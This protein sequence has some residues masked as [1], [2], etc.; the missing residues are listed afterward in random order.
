M[1]T[2]IQPVRIEIEAEKRLAE[3]KPEDYIPFKIINQE[4]G[5]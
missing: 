2:T 5:E 1:I 3:T 4:L